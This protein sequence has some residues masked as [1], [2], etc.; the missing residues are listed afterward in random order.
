MPSVPTGVR[1]PGR[2]GVVDPGTD[3][4][5]SDKTLE[6][7]DR[8]DLVVCGPS[9]TGKTHFLDALG[10]AAIGHGCHVQWFSL[11]TLGALIN[12][13][14]VDDSTSR[15]IRKIMRADLIRIDDIGLLPVATETA[16]ALYRVD[17][18]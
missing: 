16:E 15:A 2:S 6:W 7:V 12:R 10:H 8:Q 17:T 18:A 3:T 9:G 11:E 13:H 1:L 4:T 5:I 14:R